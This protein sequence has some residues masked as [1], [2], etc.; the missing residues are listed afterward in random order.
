VS[1][2]CSPSR[3]LYLEAGHGGDDNCY[4]PHALQE[5]DYELEACNMMTFREHMAGMEHIV[6]PDIRPEL[7]TRRIIVTSWIDGLK[8][9]ACKSTDVLPLCGTLLNCYLIQLLDTGFLH[10]DPVCS[11]PF[12]ILGHACLLVC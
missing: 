11:T 6:V 7:T 8:L 3:P 2:R 1:L 5:M 4:K 12:A 9:S 10:A